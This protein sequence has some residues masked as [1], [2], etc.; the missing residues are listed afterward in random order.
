[1]RTGSG[2]LAGRRIFVVEDDYMIATLIA[3]AF[4]A[5]GAEIVGPAGS[6]KDALALAKDRGRI[7]GAVLDVN[8]RGETIYP[9]ADVLQSAGV[10][11]VFLTGYGKSFIIP[12][13]ADR[14]CLQKPVRIEQLVQ[15]L[16]G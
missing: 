16:F 2:S 10:P 8:L 7:D 14:P 4:A 13:F 15:A 3:E 11:I 9:V 5:Q 6:V 12:R 1:L